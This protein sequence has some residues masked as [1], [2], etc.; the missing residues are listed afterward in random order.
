MASAAGT[1]TCASTLPTAPRCPPAARS[2]PPPARTARPRGRRGA[3]AGA[4]ACRATNRANAGLSAAQEL[5]GG[6]RAVLVD[7][8][9]ARG[10]RV[11]DVGA[12]EL[13]DDPVGRLDPV[14]HRRVDGG[15][16]LQHLQALGELPLRRDEPA[17]AGQPRLRPL[18]GE[19][20]DPV[21]LAL[22]GVVLPQLDV[23]VRLA[24][25][26]RQLAQRGAVGGGRHHRARREVGADAD[27]VGRVRPGGGQRGGHRG[28]QHLDV[29]G[30]HLQGPLGR[31]RGAVG[32]RPLEHGVRV[33]GDRAAQ[34]GA[35]VHPHD[36]RSTGQRAEVDADDEWGHGREC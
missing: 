17:V 7:A 3:R 29:V 30:G 16:L 11:A 25:E 31:Q 36:D 8:L 24:G 20:V 22:R 18:A 27:D 4:R 6:V 34:L 15:R 28:A 32:Q 10:A 35:V 13:P 5:G 9:V 33:G 2:T 19:R 12:G 26:L 1:V 21:G 23:G 14:P